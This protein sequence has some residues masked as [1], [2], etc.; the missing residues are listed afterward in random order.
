M[1]LFVEVEF[2]TEEFL[3]IMDVARNRRLH[4]SRALDYMRNHEIAEQ[5]NE[6]HH[7]I[8]YSYDSLPFRNPN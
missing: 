3:P 7:T 1:I 4:T 5:I 6:I 2:T 8:T